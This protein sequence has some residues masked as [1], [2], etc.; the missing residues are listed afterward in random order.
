MSTGTTT[1]FD[2]AALSRATESRDAEAQLAL[3]ADD[4][5]IQIVDRDHQPSNPLVI[6][7]REQIR[8]YLEDLYGREM[9]HRV[10]RAL[11]GSA[12]A[13][14]ILGCAYPDGTRVRCSMVLDLRDGLIVRQDGVQAWDAG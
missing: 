11:L 12:G 1:Q 9:T 4:A 6:Q 13:A 14:Y 10:E 7:G 8:A 2:L 3:Y 5:V